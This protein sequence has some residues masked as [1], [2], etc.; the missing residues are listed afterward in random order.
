MKKGSEVRMTLRE[1][2]NAIDTALQFEKNP[3]NIDVVI[4]T[5]LP[6]ATCGQRPCVGVRHVGIGFDWEQGQF[7]IEPKEKLMAVKHDAPQKVMEWNGNYHCPKCEYMIS[8]GRRANVIKFCSKC[9]QAVKW[10]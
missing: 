4:T 10:E 1:L 5:K 2:K 9:G 6:F 7:R 3:E 8:K